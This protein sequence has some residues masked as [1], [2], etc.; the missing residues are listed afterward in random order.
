[1][2]L[3]IFNAC[4]LVGWLMVTGGIALI[5]VPVALVAGGVILIGLTLHVARAAGVAKD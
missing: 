2:K 4:L 1:M 5:C 3:H